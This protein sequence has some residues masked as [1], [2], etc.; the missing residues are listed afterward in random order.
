MHLT[1]TTAPPADNDVLDHWLHQAEQ[2]RAA[3]EALSEYLG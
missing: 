2:L 3:A 1:P